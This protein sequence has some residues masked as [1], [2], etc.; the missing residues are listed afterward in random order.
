MI[1]KIQ[2]T[3]TC[4]PIMQV[5]LNA[6][7]IIEEV[8]KIVVSPAMVPA[9]TVLVRTEAEVILIVPN[10]SRQDLETEK[11]RTILP[12]FPAV[13]V[14]IH[15]NTKLLSSTSSHYRTPTMTILPDIQAR[16]IWKTCKLSRIQV[17]KMPRICRHLPEN[18][19]LRQLQQ[20]KAVNSALHSSLKRIPHL[21]LSLFL[22]WL[23]ECRLVNHLEGQ[24]SELLNSHLAIE[25]L[26]HCPRQS[27]NRIID[28][29]GEIGTGIHIVAEAE[30][31]D[32]TFTRGTRAIQGGTTIDLTPVERHVAMISDPT[33]DMSVTVVGIGLRNRRDRKGLFSA[34]S[35]DG[36]CQ[37]SFEIRTRYTI[38][39]LVTNLLLVPALMERF[40]K[41]YIYIHRIKLR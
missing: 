11:A 9:S 5:L 29:I 34:S 21:L 3:A 20:K 18:L 17:L 41:P 13:P 16:G 24:P 12:N 15:P 19:P 7:A 27:I 31:I 14:R 37:K 10:G 25:C 23:R 8:I 33:F 38:A 2:T 26:D 6:E 40:S 22:I 1:C 4:L 39:N 30:T 28:W 35:P 32:E 36:F